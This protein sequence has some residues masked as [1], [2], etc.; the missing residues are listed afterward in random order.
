MIVDAFIPFKR[1]RFSNSKFG[2]VRY[3]KEEEAD[4][5]IRS[6][7]RVWWRGHLLVVKRATIPSG[8]RLIWRKKKSHLPHHLSPK[9]DQIWRHNQVPE[10]QSPYSIEGVEVNPDGSSFTVDTEEIDD[11]W[12]KTC[13]VGIVRDYKIIPMIEKAMRTEGVNFVIIKPLG[14]VK[15]LLQFNTVEDMK[16]MLQGSRWWLETWF[17][18]VYEWHCREFTLS[19][20]V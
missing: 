2:V 20:R 4:E 9:G 8:K 10:D 1:R 16:E 19:S 5:A 6:F 7:N 11:S 18:E 3:L 13:V 17:D 15:V 12:V 14:G